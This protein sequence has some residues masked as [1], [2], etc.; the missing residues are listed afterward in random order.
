[1]GKGCGVRRGCGQ[2]LERVRVW[3]GGCGCFVRGDAYKWDERDEAIGIEGYMHVFVIW[4][5]EER[6]RRNVVSSSA[7]GLSRII[8]DGGVLCESCCAWRAG[9]L[10]VRWGMAYFPANFHCHFD[11]KY[12][13]V[14]GTKSLATA[15]CSFG[16]VL[17]SPA[18]PPGLRL[19][20]HN[21]GFSTKL[22]H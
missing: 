14:Y 18:G 21:V 13:Y 12:L 3:C 20:R 1:M 17:E 16:C 19:R 11:P 5:G 22:G 15:P 8:S 10:N 7:F 4:L 6:G 2:K 9:S